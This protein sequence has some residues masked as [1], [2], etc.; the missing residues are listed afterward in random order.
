MKYNPN[1][2][3]MFKY[4]SP[5]FLCRGFGRIA[6]LVNKDMNKI[7]TSEICPICERRG[8]LKIKKGD[9]EL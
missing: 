7:P 2:L 1:N 6:I 8:F 9:L 4:E 5:C 3:N